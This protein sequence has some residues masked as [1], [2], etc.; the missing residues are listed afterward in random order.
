MFGTANI[1]IKLEWQGTQLNVVAADPAMLVQQQL[2]RINILDLDIW[3]VRTHTD[4][5]HEFRILLQ[6]R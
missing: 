6:T 5:A 4:A 1:N 2:R 3:F